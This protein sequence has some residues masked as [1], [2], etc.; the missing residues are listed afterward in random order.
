MGAKRCWPGGRPFRVMSLVMATV[1]SI[2]LL[3]P[4]PAVWAA[5][6]NDNFASALDISSVFAAPY[7]SPTLN[8]NDPD[9]AT[10][11][12]EESPA[13]SSCGSFPAAANTRSVWYRFTATADGWVTLDTWLSDYDTVLEVWSGPAPVSATISTLNLPSVACD[14]DSGKDSTR[15]E[16]TFQVAIGTHYYVMVRDYGTND[17]GGSLTVRGWFFPTHQIFVD[18]VNGDDANNTG[19]QTLPFK[20][21]QQSVN[22]VT[23]G[24]TVNVAAGAYTENA[25]IAKTLTLTGTGNPTATSFTLNS[26]AVVSTSTGISAT[27]IYVNPG[28]RL[29]D[30]VLLATVSGAINVGAGTYAQ[31][32]SISKSLTLQGPSSGPRAV[33]DPASGDA[34]SVSG[35]SATVRYLDLTGAVNGVSVS[36]GSVILY[37]NNISGNTTSG[38]TTTGPVVT[39]TENWWG[40]ATG[41][42]HSS[43]P[44]GLGQSVSNNVNFTPWCSTAAPT[45]TPLAGL[46]TQLVFVTQPTNTFAGSPITPD[47]V[48]EARDP[49][50]NRAVS[51]SNPVTL[52]IGTNPGGGVLSGA[53]PV[54]A[55]NGIITFTG[56]SINQ[57]GVGYTLVASAPGL[58][59]T[60]SLSFTIYNNA[61]NAVDDDV[62]TNEDTSLTFDPRAN[63]GNGADNDPE[64][65]SLTVIAVGT[66]PNGATS[67]TGSSITYTPTANFNGAA[68]FTYTI[69]DFG[70]VSD[71]ATVT[72][73]V[74]PVNDPPDA[75]NDSA[76]V[77]EDSGANAVTVLSN[78]TI[79]P[80][81]GE[82]LTITAKTDG[83]NGAVTIT[84]GGSGL[85]YTPNPDYFGNDNFTYTISDGVLTD[86][87]TVSVTVTN[88]NDPPTANDDTAIVAEDSGTS[89]LPVLANDTITPDVGESLLIIANSDAANGTVTITGGGTGLT[90]APFPSFFGMDTFTYTVSDGPGGMD[91]ATVTVTVTNVNDPPL[92]LD[93]TFT[94]T[95]D[96][97][98]NVF[99]SPLA[100]DTIAPDSGETLTITAVTQGANGVVGFTAT[101]LVYTPT[102]NYFGPDSFTYTI[103]DGNGGADT[104]TV[105][106]NVTAVN[107]P[108]TAN[109]DSF[110]VLEDSSANALAVL[111]NDTFAPDVGEALTITAKTDGTNGAVAIT[112]G[113]SGLTYAPAGDYFGLDSFNYTI[114]DGSP[115]TDTAAVSLTVL[116]VNDPPSFALASTGL[117]LTEDSGAQTIPN[118]ATSISVG[119]ANETGQTVTFTLAN[120]DNS[121]FSVQPA[122]DS[123]GT[124]IFTPAPNANGSVIVTAQLQ[125][126]GGAANGGD[127]TSAAQT[128]T[129]TITPVNDPPTAANDALSVLED[130]GL[131][132]LD[133][134]AN[135]SDAPDFTGET[136]TI[137]AVTQGTNG[138]V[139]LV[140]TTTVQYVPN[141]NYYGGDSFTYTLSDGV[142]TATAS[143]SLTV[144]P[145]NDQPSFVLSSTLTLAEDAGAQTVPGWAS[146]ISAGPANEAGQVLTFT[147]TNTNN[148]LFAVQPGLSPAGTLT[149]T[150]AP[151]ANG[152]ATVLATLQDSGGTA[153]GGDDTSPVQ[154]F[155][156]TLTEVNDPPTAN[157]DTVNVAEDSAAN[158][159]S[160][161]ANDSNAPDTT[162][163]TLTIVGVTP[164]ANGA[165]GFTASSVAYTPTTNFFG[166]DS[167]TYVL[168]DGALTDT[169]TVTVTV[170]A[171]NDPP[172]ANDDTA[173]VAANSGP[174]PVDVLANDDI[175]PDAGESLNITLVTQGA[176]GTAAITGGGTGLTYTPN[177]NFSGDDTF[178][179]TISD[180]SGGTDTAAVTVTVTAITLYR[181]YL[182]GLHRM[183]EPA[184]PDLVGSFGLSS[185]N[186][187]A[188]QPVTVTVVIT[189]QGPAP[190]GQFWIDFYINP[191]TPPTTANVLWNTVCSLTPCYGIAWYVPGTLQPGQSITLNSTPGGFCQGDLAAANPQGYCDDNTIWPGYFASGA[192]DLYMY[193]DSFNLGVATGAVLESNETNNRSEQHGLSVLGESTLDFEARRPE[194]LPSR[195]ARP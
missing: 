180:G 127:D 147:L 76:T 114:T 66:T 191:S 184:M 101:T 104:A 153:N 98:A 106:V 71:T 78:D 174:N 5:P 26:G 177:P 37:R 70:I 59:S 7:T 9:G 19:S 163:E 11:E 18:V 145:V 171:A 62:S 58:T 60:T 135:D 38:V 23:A 51:F 156:I 67:F 4:V 93:D 57:A 65:D 24:G 10:R 34:V 134:M 132:T 149:F 110:V 189:N 120:T 68:V 95:E 105:N 42:A 82:T 35:G 188:G 170:S 16:V 77:A 124:L 136:L 137:V 122:I 55:A 162:P 74:N 154:T 175:A 172:T 40:D 165:V 155:T 144:L 36:G 161:M 12:A 41:P 72:V 13:L 167:F 117:T 97:L 81:A 195:V 176:N 53:N 29:Q 140:P 48:V 25:V 193:V 44:G 1:L 158:N 133:V 103:S 121:L 125:D 89:S 8:T 64:G 69:T 99:A 118:W 157:D 49:S 73:T 14:D 183:P 108:P 141:I 50:G 88:V 45:C 43:N 152:S 32:V 194:D 46:A 54:V 151:N 91:S 17:T 192:T 33:I 143:V 139:V 96:S 142:F 87:A 111:S 56:M 80:D 3:A 6:A 178:T 164:A 21:I 190:A 181:V 63:H 187:A 112:G 94:V 160:V 83:A 166:T 52:T 39:A 102:A 79:A 119:P 185:A 90:Y 75:L 86:T 129:I 130:A 116:A 169:A 47:P 15:S 179:Y 84:G 146:S 138:G 148:G 28:A 92:A 173:T 115:L 20:T 168:S 2:G 186:P 150:P 30:G 109:A 100:N 85:T 61:P 123:S 107:D 126:S 128:F 131:Q 27:T 31:R 182:P 113:G 159:L 22:T